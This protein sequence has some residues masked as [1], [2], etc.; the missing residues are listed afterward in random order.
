M[1]GRAIATPG[2]FNNGDVHAERKFI[3]V[4]RPMVWRCDGAGQVDTANA[5]VGRGL[6]SMHEFIERRCSGAEDVAVVPSFERARKP[7]VTGGEMQKKRDCSTTTIETTVPWATEPLKPDRFAEYLGSRKLFLAMGI[8][9][10][11]REREEDC[12]MQSRFAFARKQSLTGVMPNLRFQC[13][14]AQS[15]H[16]TLEGTHGPRLQ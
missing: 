2:A 4:F 3:W 9:A 13:A 7:R 5:D 11:K 12:W 15:A 8:S 10:R 14:T 6:I 1:T 16:R